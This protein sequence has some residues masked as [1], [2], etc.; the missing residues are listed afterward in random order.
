[1]RGASQRY[2]LRADLNKIKTP[3]TGTTTI[4]AAATTTNQIINGP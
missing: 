2:I 1:L 4:P 3:A